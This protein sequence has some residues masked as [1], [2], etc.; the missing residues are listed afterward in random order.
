VE[1]PSE[2]YH[3]EWGGQFENL[4]RAQTRLMIVVPMALALIA[5][6]L[7]LSFESVRLALL[8]FTGVPLAVTG[9]VLALWIR[10]MPFS[11]CVL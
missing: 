8:V 7:Y 11:I 10:E 2:R 1:L 9:G 5:L 3:I 4:E 6:L